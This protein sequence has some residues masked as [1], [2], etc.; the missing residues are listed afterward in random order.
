[1]DGADRN[2][3]QRCYRQKNKIGTNSDV[4]AI[5]RLQTD[6]TSNGQGEEDRGQ[7]MQLV[8]EQTGYGMMPNGCDV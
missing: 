7:V 6:N 2:V 8:K 4:S 1:M 5:D 3:Y